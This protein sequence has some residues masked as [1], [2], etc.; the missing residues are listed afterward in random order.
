MFFSLLI[1]GVSLAVAAPTC[2]TKKPFENLVVFGDR[3]AFPLNL[4]PERPY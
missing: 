2:G 4:Y 1:A 3:W